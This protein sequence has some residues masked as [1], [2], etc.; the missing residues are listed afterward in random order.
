M[1]VWQEHLSETKRQEARGLRIKRVWINYN[2][3]G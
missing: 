3:T 1:K 2:A